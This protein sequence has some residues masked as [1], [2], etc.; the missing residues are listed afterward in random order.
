MPDSIKRKKKEEDV[1]PHFRAI[2]DQ[3]TFNRA[4]K[5]KPTEVQ[6]EL[7]EQAVTRVQER[8][9]F[10]VINRLKE[11]HQ[12]EGHYINMVRY[13]PFPILAYDGSADSIK[14]L[15]NWGHTYAAIMRKIASAYRSLGQN[16]LRRF[17][18]VSLMKFFPP[19][20]L[21]LIENYRTTDALAGAHLGDDNLRGRSVE[22]N[23]GAVGGLDEGYLVAEEVARTWIP[24]QET[25]N[26][27]R[28]VEGDPVEAVRDALRWAYESHC[29]GNHIRPAPSPFIASVEHDD[30]YGSTVS[31]CERL[32]EIGE[33][34]YL[35]FARELSF[36]NGR[37]LTASGRPVDLIYMDCHLEDFPEGHPVLE[38][39]NENAVAMDCS[40]F[41]HLVLRS[42]VILALL[43]SPAFLKV[44]DLD[45]HER[46]MLER[47]LMPSFLWRRKTFME[48]KLRFSPAVNALLAD[49]RLGHNPFP[50]KDPDSA[51][52]NGDEIVVKIA[53]GS[54]Y[55]GSAVS[56]VEQ[57]GEGYKTRDAAN[58]IS[59]LVNTLAS[60]YTSLEASRILESVKTPLKAKIK[61]LVLL[62]L[63]RRLSYADKENKSAGDPFWNEVETS[64][65][66]LLFAS[67]RDGPETISPDDFFKTLKKPLRIAFNIDL[68]AEKS[69]SNSLWRKL[70]KETT[71]ALGKAGNPQKRKNALAQLLLS[72][73][74]VL[75]TIQFQRQ[76]GGKIYGA[77]MD[78]IKSVVK[79]KEKMTYAKLARR[80]MD[81]IERFF[82]KDLG[83]PLPE[84]ER[85]QVLSILLEPFIIKQRR[86]VNPVIL[87]PYVIPESL[88]GESGLHIMNRVHI[89]FTKTG[90]R[91]FISGAQA[92]FLKDSR[93]DNRYKMTGSLWINT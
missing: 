86:S 93:P 40:P 85:R 64:W 32:R 78:H 24:D 42:K 18:H 63:S 9:P 44:L 84:G 10:R 58:L 23:L 71:K 76:G 38:A 89:L 67:S 29:L 69:A 41:A 25:E 1:D 20:L 51:G 48:G 49:R 62:S 27:I 70:E 45:Q 87:Q 73:G 14:D 2:K 92:F 77:L 6:K 35:C 4:P 90:T 19:H 43:C 55:G 31:I 37:L 74:Q 61:E 66:A 34:A 81:V 39:A 5:L 56:V 15:I 53:I 60:K 11:R 16:D 21:R 7:A 12:H 80:V 75:A 13:Y 17:L 47:H 28:P 65:E 91:A 82:E 68:A 83:T 59:D 33:D 72:L 26:D 30:I 46:S 8:L 36:Q 52:E 22:W 88:Y 3:R 54:V 79:P 57:K 50:I